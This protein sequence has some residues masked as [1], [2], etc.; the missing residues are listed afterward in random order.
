MGFSPSGP[1]FDAIRRKLDRP[2]ALFLDFDG[3]LVPI[4]RR[5]DLAVLDPPGKRL[6]QSLSRRVPTVII[7]GRSMEDVRARVGVAGV[8]YVGNHGLEI[9]G[10][11]LKYK[12][13]GL[14]EIIKL[15]E[16]IDIKLEKAFG[17]IPGL[18]IENKT[19]TLSVH[20]RLVRGANRN[21]AARIFTR[22]LA[23]FR[24]DGRVRI[25][26]GKAV[27]EVRPPLLWD[28][29]RAVGWILKQAEFQDRWPLY[30][31]D[32]RTDQDALKAVKRAG[33]GIWVGSAAGKG[34]ARFA[35]ENP[36]SV[37]HFLRWMLSEVSGRFGRMKKV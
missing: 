17:S 10:N 28:K 32:D 34:A 24:N 33:L 18:I 14:T 2:M 31:G 26:R 11:N 22:T 1:L 36:R 6:I 27:W 25:T 3:T 8:S 29:G 9:E 21:K 19:C 16:K 20:Y 35:L 13:I 12:L 37:G 23:E 4:A 5:P 15:I 7:S 30:I